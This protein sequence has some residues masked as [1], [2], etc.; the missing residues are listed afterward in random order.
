MPFLLELKIQVNSHCLHHCSSPLPPRPPHQ[1]CHVA[2][3]CQRT[4][5]NSFSHKIRS[6]CVGW[7]QSKSKMAAE[8]HDAFA[9]RNFHGQI[10]KMTSFCTQTAQTEFLCFIPRRK[11]LG[12]FFRLLKCQICPSITG[13]RNSRERTARRRR[14]SSDVCEWCPEHDAFFCYLSECF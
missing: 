7:T 10:I 3:R 8:R 1:N 4:R 14:I 5:P 2:F 13:D 11:I 9:L 6:H 12:L